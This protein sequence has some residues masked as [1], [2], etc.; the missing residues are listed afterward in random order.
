[1]QA[2]GFAVLR[3]AGQ[4]PGQQQDGHDWQVEDAHGCGCTEGKSEQQRA[5]G[6]GTEPGDQ[7]QGRQPE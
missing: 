4:Q 5:A 1:V 2:A 7:R 6:A 3:L